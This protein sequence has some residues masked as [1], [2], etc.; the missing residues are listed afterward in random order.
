MK[1]MQK[2]IALLLAAMLAV[3][4][5]PTIFAQEAEQP[6]EIAAVSEPQENTGAEEEATQEVAE[7]PEGES[8]PE[9]E[10]PQVP[11]E[12]SP[13]E[14]DA[15][16]PDELPEQ[17]EEELPPEIP[18]EQPQI[19]A[20][21]AATVVYK[22]RIDGPYDEQ[23]ELAG[24]NDTNVADQRFTFEDIKGG[25]T[26]YFLLGTAGNDQM[27][28]FGNG[29]L[30]N[31]SDL[32]DDS[33]FQISV[34]K[35]YDQLVIDHAEVVKDL[36]LGN[37][38]E[39]TYL[40]LVLNKIPSGKHVVY[41]TGLK[42]TF[43]AKSDGGTWLESDAAEL[44]TLMWVKGNVQN[45]PTNGDLAQ[46]IGFYDANGKR[47][48]VGSDY[49]G[50][51]IG[52]GWATLMETRPGRTVYMMLGNQNDDRITQLASGQVKASDLVNSSHFDMQY[53][54]SGNGAYLLSDIKP[55]AD[56]NL[57]SLPRGSFL[58]LVF[59][60]DVNTNE[61]TARIDITFTAKD[62]VPGSWTAGDTVDFLMAIEF[63]NADDTGVECEVPAPLGV[64]D[65]Q[66]NPLKDSK[67][68][69]I[70]VEENFYDGM[71]NLNNLVAKNSAIY[72][73]VGNQQND[74]ATYHKFNDEIITKIHA[75]EF[76]NSNYFDII[77]QELNGSGKDIIDRVETVEDLKLGNLPRASYVKITLKEPATVADLAANLTVYFKAKTDSPASVKG[78]WTRGDQLYFKLGFWFSSSAA[79]PVNGKLPKVLEV[80]NRDTGDVIKNNLNQDFPTSGFSE[81]KTVL[82]GMLPDTVAYLLL[83]DQ[84][85]TFNNGSIVALED[86]FDSKLFFCDAQIIGD[87][88]AVKQ[89]Y[90]AG[91]VT[92]GSTRRNCIKIQTGSFNDVVNGPLEA[93]ISLTFTAKD[94]DNGKGHV[95]TTWK[96]ND[97]AEMVIKL[98]VEN[99]PIDN[100]PIN[101]FNNIAALSF[102]P[103][104]GV[105][106]NY[107]WP[108]IT[109]PNAA[110]DDIVTG[111]EATS[112]QQIW[113][114]NFRNNPK[115]PSKS[116]ATLTLG[117]LDQNQMTNR[118]S[119][120]IYKVSNGKLVDVTSSFTYAK[121]SG[122]AIEGWSTKTTKLDNYVISNQ[123]IRLKNSGGSS[124][125]STGGSSGGS[126]GGGGGGG[127]GGRGGSGNK[128]NT[129]TTPAAKPAVPVPT[130]V[131]VKTVT[132]NTKSA[133]ANAITAAQQ[134]NQKETTA[135]VNI[136]TG[137]EVSLSTL[138][139]MAQAAAQ[140][141]ANKGIKLNT[142]LCVSKL[143][144]DGKKEYALTI[145]P[146]AATLTTDLKLGLSANDATVKK[147]LQRF[148]NN[149][150]SVVKFE[151][152]GTFGMPVEV[153]CK[154]D[155]SKLNTATLHFY[156]YDPV[157]NTIGQFDPQ[158][159]TIDQDGYL[160]F[161]TT[162]GNYVVITDKPLASK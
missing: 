111:Y 109:I 97:K 135:V 74:Q 106:S 143:D 39:G 154:A 153:T 84:K 83:D 57:G 147:S 148:F 27:I 17:P 9:Q 107:R 35:L 98:K 44:E 34:T 96:L 139:A 128:K 99:A 105:P 101:K 4:Y 2:G 119:V 87:A 12:E 144:K 26:I 130:P 113:Y 11:E 7:E 129:T 60:E 51:Y 67:G 125:G 80:R 132:A 8:Q 79:V 100:G 73:M 30:A 18:E 1:H 92:I 65:E 43:T 94:D 95:G 13:G 146:A 29:R 6:T 38:P 123:P 145:N 36:E 59:D 126:S 10:E 22:A 115:I 140:E 118:K 25:Q 131:D 62:T 46:P 136:T 41:K 156:S 160:H 61:L 58:E 3:A 75:S 70:D 141:S 31:V 77:I 85:V 81:G 133:V 159:Y 53:Q 102:A 117:I 112:G 90:E 151:Q 23:G 161:T 15:G 42:V 137:S 20:M 19:V 104:D 152:V 114:Y 82:D 88:K 66:G 76:T 162:S 93:E 68:V 122:T 157:A 103:G 120:Y 116:R 124:G 158:N 24:V 56:R 150:M 14:Q 134:S 21:S 47:F 32:T 40:K 16:E 45:G 55:I 78:E 54:V 37:L 91:E 33:K 28:D 89:V 149:E 155:L 50:G 5:T 48:I 108:L 64:Y 127:G 142:R 52:D 110:I 69:P 72:L 121:S 86:L 71:G 49:S 63:V 138:Q